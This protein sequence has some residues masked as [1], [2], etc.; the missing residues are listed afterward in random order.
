MWDLE[1]LCEKAEQ[2]QRWTCFVTSVPLKVSSAVLHVDNQFTALSS[3][4]EFFNDSVYRSL[5]VLQALQMLSPSFSG[6]GSTRDHIEV[7]HLDSRHL[8]GQSSPQD[9][10]SFS[11]H[12]T[13][14]PTNLSGLGKN[15]FLQA[16]QVPVFVPQMKNGRL[17][18]LAYLG[19]VIRWI[20][21]HTNDAV[22]KL[23][24]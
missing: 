18:F 24:R 20:S 21:C 17:E 4:L 19:S 8:R 14:D 22:R 23:R 11:H 13:Y 12:S 1:E 9:I 5:E 16:R 7:L 3:P 6:R 15:T 10:Y 2:L